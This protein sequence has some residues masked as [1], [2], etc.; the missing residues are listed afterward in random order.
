MKSESNKIKTPLYIH[1]IDYLQVNA[2]T[3][4]VENKFGFSTEFIVPMFGYKYFS[5]IGSF[6]LLFDIT[7][8]IIIRNNNVYEVSRQDHTFA[9]ISN[10][11]I[12]T[13][14][15]PTNPIVSNNKNYLTVLYFNEI[16][17]VS[18][19]NHSSEL[20]F[21]A[22]ASGS[23]DISASR[24]TAELKIQNG[25]ICRIKG[26]NYTSVYDIVTQFTAATE[27]N[28]QIIKNQDYYIKYQICNAAGT[29][30]IERFLSS[31]GLFFETDQDFQNIIVRLL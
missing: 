18:L 5:I 8:Q 11:N 17:D 1:K 27:L 22:A 21:L 10:S 23:F 31:F 2:A 30:L 14:D 13:S 20:T 15:A 12:I 16:V 19:F 24:F 6:G 25:S 3:W 4:A 28:A 29:V 26:L 9:F 7:N